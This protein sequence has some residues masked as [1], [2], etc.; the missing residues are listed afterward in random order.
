[1]TGGG[2]AEQIDH[3]VGQ[4]A[5]VAQLDAQVQDAG[6]DARGIQKVP[7]HPLQANDLP[8]DASQRTPHVL[9]GGQ[10]PVGQERLGSQ[11][12][13]AEGVAQVAIGTVD[14]V[15]ILTRIDPLLE[16]LA[17][18]ALVT[19]VLVVLAAGGE[20]GFMVRNL[21]IFQDGHYYL[22]ALSIPFVGRQI[23]RANG[24][25]FDVFWGRH[26]A[27]IVGR[28]KARL[29]ARYGLWFETPNPQNILVQLDAASRPTGTLV[30]RDVGDG[31]C[32]TDVELV[33]EVPWTRLVADLRPETRSS[34]WAFGEAGDHSVEAA[35][36]ERWYALHDDAYFGELA[37]WFPEL[38]PAASVIGNA[39]LGHWNAAL[40]TAD[41]ASAIARAFTRRG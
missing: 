25:P 15:R 8:P 22:P 24:E 19:E 40:R 3:C 38:T 20:S 12:Q 18:V 32:A 35:T 31:E 28:V 41:S 14:W 34:F 23:A 29:F 17:E 2:R 26:F 11:L 27:E 5:E 30:F 39:R 7:D 6:L 36:L 10:R 13:R 37:G 9:L 21:Q 4:V 1:M 16:P 33:R